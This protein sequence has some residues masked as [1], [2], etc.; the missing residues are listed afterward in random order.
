MFQHVFM[1]LWS[2]E[3]SPVLY[4][5]HALHIMDGKAYQDQQ[6]AVKFTTLLSTFDL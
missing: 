2:V 6:H 5:K 4:F 1:R 3:Y